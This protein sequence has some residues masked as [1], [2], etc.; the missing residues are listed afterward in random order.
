M[1]LLKDKKI[2]LGITGSIAAYKALEL[3]RFFIK[4][5]ANVK[6][7]MSE[8]AKRFI[9]PLSFEALSSNIVISD[10]TES[11]SNENNHIKVSKWADIFV[12]A[13]IT[14]NTINKLANGIADNLLTSTALA[15][16]KKIVIATA[17]NTAMFLHKTTQ[18]SLEKLKSF[19]YT[20]I[21]SQE[22]LLACG[23][24]GNGALAKTQTIFIECVK[25]LQ[26]KSC[27][28]GKNVIVTGGGTIEKID[29]VRY[30]SNFSS[31]KMAD[32]LAK[33]LFINGANVTFIKTY[34]NDESLPIKYLYVESA[35]E[36]SRAISECK[37]KN[38]Y[39]FMAAA[40]GDFRVKNRVNGKIKKDSLGD[41]FSI[42]FEKNSDI[43]ANLE[44]KEIK[45]IGFKAELDRENGLANAQNMLINKKVDVVCLNIIDESNPFGSEN[46]KITLI[47]K[48]ST[49]ELSMKSKLEISF[50]ILDNL[51][52]L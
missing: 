52:E 2:L 31:G 13:P 38:D 11:W 46:N 27:W 28:N 3:V 14:A 5:G 50:E 7:L 8:N 21:N 30:V 26:T 24:V 49:K 36:M 12:I 39:L 17:A 45:T 47:T 42:E 25:A 48:T 20:I 4:N 6:I 23:D 19:N 37:N 18:S 16:T 51:K 41:T 35:E 33:A 10:D 1:Q 9:T 22:K 32:A 29:N 15:F 44:K 43:I 40:V 34:K